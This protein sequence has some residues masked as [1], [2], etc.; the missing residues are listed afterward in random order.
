MLDI[1][2]WLVEQCEAGRSLDIEH[3]RE[4]EQDTDRSLLLINAGRCLVI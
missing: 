1:H 3:N 2:N 4:D